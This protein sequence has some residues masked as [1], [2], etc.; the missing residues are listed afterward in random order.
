MINIWKFFLE[1]N[2]GLSVDLVT[3][4]M[5]KTQ[6]INSIKEEAIYVS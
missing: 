4:K 1:D 2:L 5:L 6:V 3:K